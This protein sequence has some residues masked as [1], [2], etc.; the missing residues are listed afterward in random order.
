MPI[1]FFL[2]IYMFV[3]TLDDTVI[4]VYDARTII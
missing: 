3:S 4:I 1:N 2:G